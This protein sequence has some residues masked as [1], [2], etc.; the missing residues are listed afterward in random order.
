MRCLREEAHLGG[1]LGGERRDDRQVEEPG[2][3]LDGRGPGPLEREPDHHG[4]QRRRAD[5]AERD[6][7]RQARRG[8][9]GVEVRGG[10]GRAEPTEDQ[11]HRLQHDAGD[12]QVRRAVDRAPREA[13]VRE[14]PVTEQQAVDHRSEERRPGHEL[15]GGDRP[16][17]LRRARERDQETGGQRHRGEPEDAGHRPALEQHQGDPGEAHDRQRDRQAQRPRARVVARDPSCGDRGPGR[18]RQQEQHRAGEREEPALDLVPQRGEEQQDEAAGDGLREDERRHAGGSLHPLVTPSPPCAVKPTRAPRNA[19][20]ARPPETPPA[21]RLAAVDDWRSYDAVAEPYA[22]IHAPRL[23]E[24][25]GDLVSIAGVS[26][27]TKVLDV[28]TGTAVAAAAASTVGGWVVGVDESL[29]ML[30]HAEGAHRLAAAQAIDLPFRNGAF[31]VI[32]A[33]FVVA[34]FTKYQTALHDMLRVLRPGG[35]MA[36]TAWADGQDDLTRAWVEQVH[37]VVPREVLQP[38]LDE[39]LPWRERFRDRQGLEEAMMD[40]GL[41]QVRSEVRRYRFTFTLDEYVEGLGTWATG[42]FVRSMLGEA[43]FGAFLQRVR[44]TFGERFADPVN[45][46]REVLFSTGVKP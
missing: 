1:E 5:H 45:D 9:E 12:Q 14:V 17:S 42:R 38:A 24:P 25:A 10:L 37:T 33:N 39:R 29:G 44:G 34:H 27:G 18:R 15:Q 36:L 6:P 22:R 31:D 40:A 7:R 41:R 35:R 2:R 32:I 8:E 28:G 19:S 46:F 3:R 21:G 43:S 30:V 13:P 23:A 20:D 11:G 16:R 4:D 26:A